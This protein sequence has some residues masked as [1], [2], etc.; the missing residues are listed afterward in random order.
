MAGK[1]KT[2]SDAYKKSSGLRTKKE[3]AQVC[4]RRSRIIASSVTFVV[5]ALFLLLSILGDANADAPTLWDTMKGMLFGVFG[6]C[7]FLAGPLL[8]WFAFLIGSADDDIVIADE[9]PLRILKSIVLILFLTG[10]AEILFVGATPADN[11]SSLLKLLY[12]NGKNIK[13]GGVLSF[14]IAQP[15]LMFGRAGAV[16]I[17]LLAAAAAIM[18]AKGVS[19]WHIVKPAAVHAKNARE[20]VQH[21]RAERAESKEALRE[22]RRE[23]HI[24]AEELRF[25]RMSENIKVQNYKT[26]PAPSEAP[27]KL[28]G[29]ALEAAKNILAPSAAETEKLNE[30]RVIEPTPE[31]VRNIFAEADSRHKNAKVMPD[32][33][34]L[35]EGIFAAVT[36][37]KESPQTPEAPEFP[38]APEITREREPDGNYI[39]AAAFKR[40][41]VQNVKTETETREITHMVPTGIKEQSESSLHFA[42]S[43][44]T[45]VPIV[46]E[47][48]HLKLVFAGQEAEENVPETP[49]PVVPVTPVTPV[50]APV[51]EAL[52]TYE[53]EKEA[54]TAAIL[55]RQKELEA[56][57]YDAPFDV[58]DKPVF[59]A[60]PIAEPVKAKKAEVSEEIPQ[61]DLPPLDP[62]EPFSP[63]LAAMRVVEPEDETNLVI[64]AIP[65]TLPPAE[66]L[67]E[68]VQSRSEAD[69]DHEID[70]NC[71]ILIGTLRSFRVQAS[72]VGVSRGPSVT[73]YE[74]QP[75]AGVKISKITLLVDDIALKLKAAGVRIAAVPE[76]SAVG[77]EVPNKVVETV[78]IRELVDSK[79]FET[80]KSKLAAVLGKA[81]SGDTVLCDIAKMP[82]LLIA[83][84]TGSGKSVCVNSII[85][86]ILF[87]STPD[88]VRLIMIDPKSVE[89]MIYNGIPHLL[90]PVVTDPKKAAGALSWAVTEMENRYKSFT[91]NNVRDMAGY[92]KIARERGEEIMPQIVVFIDELADLMMTAGAEVEDCIVRIAQ[93]ARA[94]GIHLVIATQRPT[95]NV[96]TGLI[97]ANIPSRIALKVASQVDSR[98]I[99]DTAGAEKL[100]GR[101]DM[102][103]KSTSMPAPMRVQGCW[104]SDKEVE[105]VVNFIKHSFTQEYDENV[106]EE[107]ERASAAAAPTKKGRGAQ[108]EPDESADD[109]DISDDKLDE[110]IDAIIESGQASTSYLQRKLKL[111]YGRAARLIDIMEQLGIV[112]RLDGSKPRQV[113]MTR[114]EWLE[115]KVQLGK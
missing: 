48:S 17:T 16:I 93:K 56:V 71:N 60:P 76:K 49:A 105:R 100:I 83:G 21:L 25:A 38:E 61:E 1:R 73:R 68:I 7:G 54:E 53:A 92:N 47:G 101:G 32:H 85:M 8:I 82:H 52:Q 81:V 72:I 3:L 30:P 109:I 79:E 57:M 87:R 19:P 110:A 80:E 63:A 113:T 111:G 50:I 26:E 66:L 46:P 44:L 91:E 84:T 37:E 10:G 90:I 108:S 98:T 88:D 78:S 107:V 114:T 55:A 18:I 20:R 67:N 9:L 31:F 5:G 34:V 106:M 112:S 51:A 70:T 95:V 69:I 13:G 64:E 43:P 35:A 99:F 40:P 2:A 4:E 29:G 24:Q 27:A 96:V 28:F 86:S 39:T 102:L 104:V 115:R 22:L 97:K 59:T 15:L 65:Y 23:R 94:A 36:A 11:F 89:F 103:F 42:K 58:S 77:V 14:V 75:A 33:P 41:S 74:V 6:I 62:S 45:P 12:E